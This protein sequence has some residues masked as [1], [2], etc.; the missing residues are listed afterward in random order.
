[1]KTTK[2]LAAFTAAVM[3]VCSFASCGK[4]EPENT[5]A[6][7]NE[8]STVTE[9]QP[10]GESE[11]DAVSEAVTSSED[12]A[13]SETVT[14]S[15]DTSSAEGAEEAEAPEER[16]EFEH[17][18]DDFAAELFKRA[19]AEKSGENIVVSPESVM[20]CMGLA[21]NGAAGT[22][23]DEMLDVLAG[24]TDLETFNEKMKK[25]HKRQ[26]DDGEEVQG[27]NRNDLQPFKILNA[28]S[29]WTAKEMALSDSYLQRIKDCFDAE[30]HRSLEVNE[31]NEWVREKTDGMID[32]AIKEL[33]PD[34]MSVLINTVTF[35]AQWAEHFVESDGSF[36]AADGTVQQVTMLQNSENQIIN[37]DDCNGFMKYYSDANYAFVGLLPDEGTS[38]EELVQ[39]LDGEKLHSL[40]SGAE[41]R[42]DPCIVSIPAFSVDAEFKMSGM[43]MDMGIKKA[44]GDADFS[45]MADVSLAISEVL[46]KAHL[47][48][49]KN[50]T[51]AAAVTTA[52]MTMGIEPVPVENLTF[53][54]PFVYAIVDLENGLPI[55][56]GVENKI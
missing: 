31:M 21:A 54:R 47:E 45:E 48:I 8:S 18:A 55:F 15:S 28:N 19:V 27:E 12:D 5:A 35:D 17:G 49:D 26:A 51:K 6:N 9:Q 34:I 2:A 11:T 56:L 50:G 39:T 25:W 20:F 13:Y 33:P 4:V 29:I 7:V 30:N 43:L 32:K 41:Y 23:R 24:G 40:I 44:F 53:D 16:G 22:T 42:H 46:Q 38:A 3:A 10:E 14:V 1:M 36:T 52:F 37:G